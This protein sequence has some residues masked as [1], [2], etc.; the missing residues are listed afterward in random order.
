MRRLVESPEVEVSKPFL[1]WARTVSFC[2]GPPTSW[3]PPAFHRWQPCWPGKVQVFD[4]S[5]TWTEVTL[6]SGR[7][8]VAEVV[9]TGSVKAST[10][11]GQIGALIGRKLVISSLFWTLDWIDGTAAEAKAVACDEIRLRMFSR[12]LR[13]SCLLCGRM[14]P[15]PSQGLA[16]VQKPAGGG[17]E[18]GKPT[19]WPATVFGL[20]LKK[21]RLPV[22]P[23]SATHCRVLL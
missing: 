23:S 16:V 10:R 15:G 18:A 19:G 8:T 6:P 5:G 13:M 4:V 21:C 12:A 1:P 17:S 11:P 22:P 20:P 7:V 14:G 9:G 2:G 3:P